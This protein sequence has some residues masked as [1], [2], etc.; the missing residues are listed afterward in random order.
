MHV[1]SVML[2]GVDLVYSF[3]HV[4]YKMDRNGHGTHVAGKHKLTQMKYML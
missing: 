2:Q 1:I 4:D 3:G